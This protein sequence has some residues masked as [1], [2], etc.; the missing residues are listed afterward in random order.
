MLKKKIVGLLLAIIIVIPC[1]C[2]SASAE[3]YTTAQSFPGFIT[4]YID[5]LSNDTTSRKG[6]ELTATFSD[7]IS[8]GGHTLKLIF[9]ST[10]KTN[11][12]V[13]QSIKG[14]FKFSDENFYNNTSDAWADDIYMEAYYFDSDIS[15]MVYLSGSVKPQSYGYNFSFDSGDKYIDSPVT[16]QIH[17]H[18]VCKSATKTL[19]LT[20]TDF[21]YVFA[22]EEE[23]QTDKITANQDKNTQAIIDNEKELQENEKSEANSTGSDGVGDIS[24]A[25]PDHSEGLLQAFKNLTKSMIHENTDCE[26]SIPTIGI[27]AIK[28]FIN[29]EI[30]LLE[31]QSFDI[32]DYFEMI[33]DTVLTLV[34][35]VLTLGLMIYCFKELYTMLK[36]IF[37]AKGDGTD[38]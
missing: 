29:D 37:T 23:I 21:E 6:N 28:P 18:I 33:P 35:A 13:H 14:S 8:S 15:E 11:V 19:K 32:G 31:K 27:P 4:P 1:F 34:R 9:N 5:S 22:T 7:T 17:T 38:E 16:F 26:L 24:S 2:L 30:V 3:T 10:N 25:V 20:F 12:A 36:L